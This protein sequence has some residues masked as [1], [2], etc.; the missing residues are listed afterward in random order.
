MMFVI[1]VMPLGAYLVRK[2]ESN[3]LSSSWEIF[4]RVPLSLSAWLFRGAVAAGLVLG[5][6]FTSV[7]AMYG[8]RFGDVHLV[9]GFDVP[10]TV[11]LGEFQGEV[12]PH[13]FRV[14]SLPLGAYPGRATVG[15]VVVEELRFEVALMGPP[16]NTVSIPKGV[17]EV[18]RT[19]VRLDPEATDPRGVCL[20]F[21]SMKDRL[22]ET[23][24]FLVAQAGITGWAEEDAQ[25]VAQIAYLG[26]DPQAVAL[27]RKARDAHPGS[28]ALHRYYQEAVRQAGGDQEPRREEYRTLAEAQPERA[29]LQ[30]LQLRLS[31]GQSF[32][33]HSAELLARFP[34]H[35]DLLRAR[36][37]ALQHELRWAELLEIWARLEE[38]DPEV[39]AAVI[40]SPATCPPPGPRS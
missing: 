15:E 14:V 19:F 20:G 13:S 24:S 4:A 30:Y 27:T 12:P 2:G 6:A 18:R 22:G 36:L 21:L 11:K 1:P 35:P 7:G 3:A 25:R 34:K 37:I 39:A 8:S 17:D 23:L 29:D 28:V 31:S 32:A 40:A 33:R 26:K 5:L 16:P 9:N 10:V 38:V